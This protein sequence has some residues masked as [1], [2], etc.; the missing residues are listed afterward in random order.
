MNVR[1][2]SR[3]LWLVAAG[4]VIS[5]CQDDPTSVLVDEALPSSVERVEI[6][7]F[8]TA[9]GGAPAPGFR[10]P[11]DGVASPDGSMFYFTAYTAEAEPRAAIYGVP[12]DGGVA[13]LLYAGDQL[14]DPTGLLMS[15]DGRTLYIADQPR[16]DDDDRPSQGGLYSIG[17]DG[18][19]LVPLRADGIG[20]PSGLA[21]SPDCSRLYVTGRTPSAAIKN[22]ESGVALGPAYD[23][24]PGLFTL[25]VEGGTASET[26][27]GAPL[28]SPTGVYVDSNNV[29]WVLDH[30]GLDDV[31]GRLFSISQIGAIDTVVKGL[32]MGAPGGVT[33][34]AAGETAFVPTRGDG[35]GGSSGGSGAALL[36][37]IK[38]ATG[39]TSELPMPEVI[40]PAGIRTARDANIL[41]VV[42]NEGGAIFRVR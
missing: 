1:V 33:L 18:A 16:A 40:A 26:Y 41:V 27:S 35:G 29:A 34:N 38:L 8:V 12:S 6:T 42:D 39:V 21:M 28:M 2:S 3:S 5:A 19:A 15:C 14:N 11:L 23:E 20:V 25:P 37:S 30:E 10:S 24:E 17:T 4:L 22:A 9:V 32:R 36:V 31:N 13:S 7:G